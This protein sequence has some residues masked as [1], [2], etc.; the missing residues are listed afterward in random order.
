MS[1]FKQNDLTPMTA[2]QYATHWGLASEVHQ[3]ENDYHWIS[4]NLPSCASMLEIGCGNGNSTKQLLTVSKR[5]VSIEINDA[6]IQIA[7]Q[8][9]QQAGYKVCIIEPGIASKVDFSSDIDCY[10]VHASVFDKKILELLPGLIFDFVIFSFFGSAPIH[11]A[12]ELGKNLDE[13]DTDY[14]MRYREKATLRA[15]EL[16]NMSDNCK[17]CVVD[18]VN[19]VSG[20]SKFDIRNAVAEDLADRLGISAN[21]ISVKTKVNTAMQKTSSSEM[22]YITNASMARMNGTP[23]IA[24]SLI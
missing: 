16:K 10:L 20:F 3:N 23:L 9:L 17:L 11:A 21:Q 18:R 13:L 19:Q 14:A 15:F 2:E 7:Q 5:V 22:Q 1:Y 8:N 12:D 6:L 24:L 4:S